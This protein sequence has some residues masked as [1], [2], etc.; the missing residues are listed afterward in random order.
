MRVANDP[1]HALY[2]RQFSGSTLRI[3]AGN[4]NLRIGVIAMQTPDLAPR[5]Y[6]SA[7]RHRAGI[8]HHQIGVACIANQGCAAFAE[9]GLDR[10]PIGLRTRGSRSSLLKRGSR[11]ISH[12]SV[13]A[14]RRQNTPWM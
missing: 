11:S 3:A 6:V 9:R 7:A 2:R 8:E 14:L 4:Q 12:S 5:I 1:A 13:V 10:C